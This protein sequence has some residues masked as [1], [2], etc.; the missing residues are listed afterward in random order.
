VLVLLPLVAAGALPLSS[1]QSAPL[2]ADMARLRERMVEEQIVA[3]GV[4]DTVVLRA[5]RTVERH[6]FVPDS[7]RPLA[8]R[9]HPLPIGEDQTISQPYIVALMTELVRPT[10][11]ARILEVGTGSGY[12]AAVLAA[13]GAEVW[14][15]EI[16]PSLA[17]SSAERLKRLGYAKVHCREGDGYAGWPSE[18]PFD[19]IVVTAAPEKIPPPLVEQLAVGG[20]LVI[21]VGGASQELTVLT[22]TEKGTKT[23]KVLP[24]RFVPM[25]G[26]AARE[27]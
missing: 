12:Q 7:L 8:Y 2:V 6:L 18:A 22:K 21:P 24:V 14:T 15:I 16:V 3:R 20:R 11:G 26:K 9:D 5:M 4:R 10:P 17:R 13:T 23:E 1:C 25:T 19:G 27:K